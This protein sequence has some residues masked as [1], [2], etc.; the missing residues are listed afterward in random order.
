MYGLENSECAGELVFMDRYRE[1]LNELAQ[2]EQKIESQS[3][4]SS[5]SSSEGLGTVGVAPG[6]RTRMGSS[7]RLTL[8]SIGSA[9]AAGITHT[10]INLRR[11]CHTSIPYFYFSITL[12]L[13]AN[14]LKE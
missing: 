13:K 10:F 9:A 5:S 4:S 1:V 6:G 12:Y 2:V 7:S 3:L 8:K 14:P 11:K